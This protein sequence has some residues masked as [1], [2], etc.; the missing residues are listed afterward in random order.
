MTGV[1]VFDPSAWSALEVGLPVDEIAPMKRFYCEGL[2]FKPQGHVDLP[3]VHIE[4]F[5][6]G[7]CLL[8]LSLSQDATRR[9]KPRPSNPSDFYIT[10][11]VSALE[12]TVHRCLAIGADLLVPVS[13]AQTQDAKTVRFA[14][15]C[16]P[17]G[18]RI[19]LVEGN[20]WSD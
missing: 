20:A 5:R 12:E 19:E 15:V 3:T 14:F 6:F 7:D 1:E 16:D 18:N 8:K 4:A 2:G 10:L 9:P 13:S 11:R 17:M